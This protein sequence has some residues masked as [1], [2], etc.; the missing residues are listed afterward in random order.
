MNPLQYLP[1]V[2]P[3][4]R[5]ATGDVI[6]EPLREGGSLLVSGLLGGPIG[7]VT[8]AVLTVAQKITG[9]DPEKI[10]A[11]QF[12]STSPVTPDPADP[13]PAAVA[14]VD[15]GPSPLSQQQLAENG[16]SSDA[17]GNLKFG[18]IEGADVLNMM[19]LRRLN[20]AAAAYASNQGV[21]QSG[22]APAG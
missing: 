13:P 12:H 1:I 18:D 21:Q 3:L 2:G 22:A 7:L 14:S 6:P 9:I 8:S 17:T 4:Y 5:A 16:I 20:A 15:P 19:E 10:A 11:A